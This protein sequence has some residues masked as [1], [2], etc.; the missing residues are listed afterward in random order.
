MAAEGLDETS[1]RRVG[2][3]AAARAACGVPAG[4]ACFFA[5]SAD[6]LPPAG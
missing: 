6:Y 2:L 1:P 5:K 3:R 4:P